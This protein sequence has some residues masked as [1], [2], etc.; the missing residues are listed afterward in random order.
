MQCHCGYGFIWRGSEIVNY[1]EIVN[2]LAMFEFP[3]NRYCFFY[4]KILKIISVEVMMVLCINSAELVASL[5]TLYLLEEVTK[6]VE[7][8]GYSMPKYGLDS[9]TE[10]K[11]GIAVV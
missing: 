5:L 7:D 11:V 9:F 1:I 3:I 10:M 6:G 4:Y 2:Y 8:D